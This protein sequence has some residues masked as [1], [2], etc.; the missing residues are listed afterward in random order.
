VKLGLQRG[1][2]IWSSINRRT[3]RTLWSHSA[4]EVQGRLYESN[5]IKGKQYKSGVRDYVLTPEVA[6]RFTWIDLGESG[7]EKAL[8]AYELI[9]GHAYDY[10][11]LISFQLPVSVRD[12]KREYC[13]ELSAL[14]MGIDH[15]GYKTPELLL[16]RAV[17]QITS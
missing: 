8:A 14:M 2:S 4:I 13:H 5:A 1:N 11:S 10:A 3:L 12:S 16:Y 9:R 6:S 15:K 17:L 7:D